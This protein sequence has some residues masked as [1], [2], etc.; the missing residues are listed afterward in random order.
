M[1]PVRV[2][3]WTVSVPHDGVSVVTLYI[4]PDGRPIAYL[5]RAIPGSDKIERVSLE[6]KD[7]T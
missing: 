5:A 2:G 6:V 1:T 7:A 3:K 4:Q